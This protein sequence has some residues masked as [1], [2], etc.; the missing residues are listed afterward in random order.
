[1]RVG[2]IDSGVGGL[3]ILQAVKLRVKAYYSYCMDNYYLPYGDKTESFIRQRLLQISQHL[4]DQYKVELIVIAC[5]TATT[6][7]ISYLRQQLPLPIVGVVPAVKPAAHYA[8]G[9][10]IIVLATPAT[11]RSHYIQQLLVDYAPDNETQLVGSSELVALAERKVWYGED[12]Q[13]QVSQ[14]LKSAQVNRNAKAMVLG[15]THFPFLRYELQA[16]LGEGIRLFDT[17]DAIARRVA[18]LAVT[19]SM[20]FEAEVTADCLISTAVLNPQQQLQLETLGF[21]QYVHWP[22]QAKG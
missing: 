13:S 2:V 10:P 9:K 16:E 22:E 15:C 7:A 18:E 20:S 19:A 17:A 6:Q 21:G 11:V 5:N 14:V 8:A 1:M 4:I 3:S 12:V